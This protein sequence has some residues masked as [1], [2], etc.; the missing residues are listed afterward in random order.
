LVRQTALADIQPSVVGAE[1][2]VNIAE[3]TANASVKQATGD[4][5]FTR[6]RAL[7]EAEAIRATGSAKAAAYRVGVQSLG[8]QGYT[9]MQLRQIVGDRDVRIVPDV[10]VNGAEA[11]QWS[12][13]FRKRSR[14]QIPTIPVRSG[15][16]P[17]SR[18]CR[19][20]SSGSGD[21]PGAGWRRRAGRRFPDRAR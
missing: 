10:A 8:A 14:G 9:V 20:G 21:S 3:L 6:L 7:G 19:P 11:G 13:V 4:A 1:Q 18:S 5:E 16:I 17:P 2:G 15:P 12:A